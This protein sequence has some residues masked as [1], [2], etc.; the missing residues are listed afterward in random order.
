MWARKERVLSNNTPSS[1]SWGLSGTCMPSNVSCGTSRD[2]LWRGDYCDN[3]D[4]VLPCC[5]IIVCN[6]WGADL[7][8]LGHNG[9]SLA[10]E[11]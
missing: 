1:L 4:S 8:L 5:I 6:Y 9:C 10:E 3:S 11:K 2:G 7:C